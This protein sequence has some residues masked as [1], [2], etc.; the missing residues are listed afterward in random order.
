MDQDEEGNKIEINMIASTDE[1]EVEK[2]NKNRKELTS[3]YM[4]VRR[5]INKKADDIA[6]EPKATQ[7]EKLSNLIDDK[8]YVM[9]KLQSLGGLDVEL[10][11]K[12]LALDV[13]IYE[14]LKNADAEDL[15]NIIAL[16]GSTNAMATKLQTVMEV[17]FKDEFAQL[18]KVHKQVFA[19]EG[20]L[21][22]MA[23]ILIIKSDFT[24]SSGVVS[25]ES[26]AKTCDTIK[27]EKMRL[28]G[29]NKP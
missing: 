1:S 7:K 28:E 23:H 25:W 18:G 9:M 2:F 19:A 14:R 26:L 20:L 27:D 12:I 5:T 22:T 11:N 17:I 3:S 29:A 8:Q 15:S 4:K 24:A 13:D 16:S 6:T 10:M 21:K